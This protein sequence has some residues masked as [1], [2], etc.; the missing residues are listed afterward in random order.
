MTKKKTFEKKI[1]KR[2]ENRRISESGKPGKCVST[3]FQEIFY[4]IK[5]ELDLMLAP[6]FNLV[7]SRFNRD[8]KKTV[9][10]FSEKRLS[11]VFQEDEKMGK[12][13]WERNFS[14]MPPHSLISSR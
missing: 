3:N 13:I 8:A 12:K 2:D 5:I 6:H 11:T 14:H 7:F 1:F 4:L 10:D 9:L